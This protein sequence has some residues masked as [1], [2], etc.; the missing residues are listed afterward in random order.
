MKGIRT[1]LELCQGGE[2]QNDITLL[3]YYK[4]ECTKTDCDGTATSILTRRQPGEVN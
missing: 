1:S 2:A 4:R 3:H